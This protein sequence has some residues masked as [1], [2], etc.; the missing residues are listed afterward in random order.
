[1]RGF[2]APPSLLAPRAVQMKDGQMFHTVTYGQRNM[3]SYASQ[4]SREDRWKVIVYIRAM[5][6]RAAVQPAAAPAKAG[7]QTGGQQ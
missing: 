6:K 3:A 7:T 5:Q 4:L 1:M 2:P